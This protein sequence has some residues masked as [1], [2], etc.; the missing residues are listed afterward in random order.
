MYRLL[1]DSS[2]I[3][4]LVGVSKDD[5]VI[6]RY[7]EYAW[8]RQSEYMIPEIEKALYSVGITL[9]DID[10]VVL[11]IGPG[12]YTGVRIPL[13]I[14]KTLNAAYGIKVVAISSLKI[15]GGV[16]EKYVALMNARS[17]RSY[18]GI[19]NSGEVIYKDG[20]IENAK[21]EDFI[22]EYLEDGYALKGS[23]AYLKKDIKVD[24]TLID[25]MLS[26]ALKD[27]AISNV[28]GLCPIYLKD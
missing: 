5:K 13:T 16:S 28:D 26:H 18:I 15:L 17:A 11:S 25:N 8:Q 7:F 10:E 2:D 1:L 9:K 20:I 19:Y 12:S 3:N 6:Y 23:L 24:D 4:L 22:K 14:A 27:E 21:L